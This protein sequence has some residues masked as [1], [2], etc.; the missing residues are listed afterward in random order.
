M[1]LSSRAR[2]LLRDTAQSLHGAPHLAKRRNKVVDDIV[3]WCREHDIEL[4]PRLTHDRLRF[5][6]ELLAQIG[7]TLTALGH[8]AIDTA[9][10]GLTSTEQARFGNREEKNIRESPREHRVLASMPTGEPRCGLASRTCDI[11][12]LDWRDIALSQFDVLVQ[13]E[14]LDSFYALDPSIPPLAERS[15]PLVLYRGDSFYGGAFPKVAEAWRSTGKAHLYLG[16]FDAKGVSLAIS[17]RATHL[18]LPPFAA[19]AQSAHVEH[20]PAKQQEYQSALRDL[21]VSLPVGH[22]LTNY[23]KVLLGD[24]RGLLQQ[25]FGSELTRVPLG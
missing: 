11:L 17:S 18:L 4:G 9:L 24:Q 21:A 14:N 10:G 2:N 23:L 12:D 7:D 8:P 15:R 20:L 6:R 13:I 25:W 5:D 16:D 22:P 1:I 3:A 19:L